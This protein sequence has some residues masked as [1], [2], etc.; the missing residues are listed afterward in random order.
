MYFNILDM[1]ATG[2]TNDSNLLY[3]DEVLFKYA[4]SDYKYKNELYQELIELNEI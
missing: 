3:K 4:I 1:L 2:C